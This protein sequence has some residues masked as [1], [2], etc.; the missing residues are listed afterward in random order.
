MQQIRQQSQA[1]GQAV[2][3]DWKR[4]AAQIRAAVAKGRMGDKEIVAQ[5][6][7]IVSILEREISAF[8]C[9]TIYRGRQLSNLRR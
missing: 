5:R 1:T 7:Q 9:G 3:E 8:S 2:A 4:Y 6:Q